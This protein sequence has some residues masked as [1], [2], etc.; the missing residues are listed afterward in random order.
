[1]PL[2]PSRNPEDAL[3]V[4]RYRLFA[5]RLNRVDHRND[6][7]DNEISKLV[8]DETRCAS[9]TICR[10]PVRGLA[11]PDAL[12]AETTQM[13][14]GVVC[15]G[16]M[17]LRLNAPDRELL[18]QS[19]ALRVYVGGA[20]A[21]VAVSLARF[22]HCASM[23]TVLPDNVLGDACLGE[24]RRQ[25]VQTS[26]IRR[27]PGR[28]GI[29]FMASGTGHR[30]S[31]IV[32]DRADSAFA[33]RAD[34]AIDWNQAL[35]GAAWLHLSGISPALGARTAEATLR[36]ARIARERGVSVSFDC[37][38]R[39]KLWETWCGDPA[40]TL[41]EI[42]DQS[43]LV[44]ADDRALE[45]VMGR[46][47]NT[48]EGAHTSADTVRRAGENSSPA[49]Q[50]ASAV[51]A[52]M[53]SAD[54]TRARFQRAAER[55]FDAFPRLRKISTTVRLEHNV[56]RHELSALLATRQTFTSTR[57]FML[58][59][60]VDRIG[61]GD[62]FAAGLL[63][64]ELS[65]MN[66]QDSLDF[67]LAAACLKHSVPGDFNLVSLAQVSELLAGRGFAVRR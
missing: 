32:Y 61:T 34:E 3:A 38:Y 21:N 60:I 28:L 4:H 54:A 8:S 30:P 51:E 2:Q 27:G 16:E 57:A 56:D 39:A 55:A 46:G 12:V 5:I 33:L 63:H 7:G 14:A 15:F 52:D 58:E 65:G 48:S 19:G 9:D 59:A 45:L 62:A 23:V 6:T 26:G 35:T 13:T 47:P 36:A 66:E 25:G 1:M 20:E 22:G 42:V 37:N 49:A 40:K 44:F 41:R 17:L 67:A 18:L 24:L 11:R 53:S 50:R 10:A 31:E 43:D 64:G 29:Y